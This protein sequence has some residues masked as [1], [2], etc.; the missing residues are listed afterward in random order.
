MKPI[1]VVATALLLL[2]PLASH[3]VAQ[4]TSDR[5]LASAAIVDAATDTYNNLEI[6]R[7]LDKGDAEGVRR[8]LM[9]IVEADC[10]ELE[11][12]AKS[13]VSESDRQKARRAI[14][15]VNTYAKQESCTRTP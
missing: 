9:E 2:A 12:L 3:S 11:Y 7:R 6:L 1:R 8:L 5:E 4:G 15:H 10:A 13:V 14:R